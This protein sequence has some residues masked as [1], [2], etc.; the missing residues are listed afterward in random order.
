MTRVNKELAHLTYYRLK[1]TPKTKP[2]PIDKI[3]NKIHKTINAF[4]KNIDPDIMKIML[5]Y[6]Y[7]KLFD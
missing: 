2:W 1:K 4:L 3:Y 6:E 5:K 7:I